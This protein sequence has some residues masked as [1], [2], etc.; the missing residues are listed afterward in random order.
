MPSTETFVGF[1][2]IVVLCVAASWVWANQVVPV[3]RSKLAISK[4]RGQVR[5]YL[6][7]LK[8][9]TDDRAME[10]WLF[11]DWLQENKSE[12]QPAIPILKKAKWNSGDNPV[13]AA[14]A[15][16]GLGV[17]FTAVTERA[18]SLF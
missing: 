14:S 9:T 4:N 13:L 15:L 10:Q 12:K 16:I 6:D 2:L 11:T 5:E 8:N 17:L 18:V 7:D 3:S 1:G